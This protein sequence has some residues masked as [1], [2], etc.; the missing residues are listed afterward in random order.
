MNRTICLLIIS[1]IIINLPGCA[2][3]P[4][5][6]SVQSGELRERAQSFI[7]D[8]NTEV[9]GRLGKAIKDSGY[10]GAVIMANEQGGYTIASEM[11]K[12]NEGLIIR[13]VSFK[14]R[15]PNN[16]PDAYES[17]MLHLMEKDHAKGT[18]KV[19]YEDF[20]TTSGEKAYK[21]MEPIIIKEL[22]LHCHDTKNAID[23]E[24]LVQIKKL[25]PNDKA[26][27]YKT[28]DLR[29]AIFV[30]LPVSQ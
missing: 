28:G 21:Y 5:V 22:C 10:G 25:Y 6:E 29:G 17:R 30:T 24:A 9:K 1:L 7:K 20:A 12:Q 16:I 26:M 8:L 2:H 13:R 11:M 18:L 19:Y 4:I 15:N 27:D 14:N 23:P 3:P